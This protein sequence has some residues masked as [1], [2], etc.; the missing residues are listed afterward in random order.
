MEASQTHGRQHAFKEAKSMIS[1]RKSS[2]STQTGVALSTTT[3]FYSIKEDS[4]TGKA[5][6]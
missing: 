1:I 4:K 3:I 6:P 5:S 2:L